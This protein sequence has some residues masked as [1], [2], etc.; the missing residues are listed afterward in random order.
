[1]N[2]LVMPKTTPPAA[3]VATPTPKASAEMRSTFT[4]TS[5]AAVRL[6]MVARIAPPK[7]VRYSSQNI[8]A[9]I[10][11]HSPNPKT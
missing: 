10:A 6:S 8:A 3:A 5:W 1:L 11:R 9:S 4:P 2:A 7:A